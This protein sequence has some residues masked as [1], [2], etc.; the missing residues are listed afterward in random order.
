M[1]SKYEIRAKKELEADGW[2]VDDKRGMSRWS[3]NRDFFNRWDL[4]AYK[5]G[6][7]RYISIKGTQGL[8]KS[9]IK[10]LEE[11][12]LPKGCTNELWAKR[13]SN[14]SYW[15]KKII[16]AELKGGEKQ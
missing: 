13:K 6:K 9:H 7:L 12:Q 10:E 8:I 1:V 2:V 11:F 14:K 15:S 16:N 4:V 5:P 3:Q